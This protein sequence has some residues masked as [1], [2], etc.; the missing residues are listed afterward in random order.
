MN[1]EK[2]CEWLSRGKLQDGNPRGRPVAHSYEE[3]DAEGM[4]ERREG[5]REGIWKLGNAVVDQAHPV[6]PTVFSWGHVWGRQK[7]RCQRR[8]NQIPTIIYLKQ[9]F[10]NGP[11]KMRVE[12]NTNNVKGSSTL[13]LLRNCF[14][15]LFSMLQSCK[16]L[17]TYCNSMQEFWTKQFLGTGRDYSCHG[18]L[19]DFKIR[20]KFR[21]MCTCCALGLDLERRGRL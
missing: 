1:V 14:V 4:E 17:H 20:H 12:F 9:A 2:Y 7:W 18:K 13:V 5:G 11:H 15:S 6:T 21:C 3:I 16:S 19:E 8:P 10:S